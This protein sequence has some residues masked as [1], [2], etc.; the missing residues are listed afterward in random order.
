MLLNYLNKRDCD[1]KHSKNLLDKLLKVVT[2]NLLKKEFFFGRY[3]CYRAGKRKQTIC[4]G[5]PETNLALQESAPDLSKC[6]CNSVFFRE[7]Q[8]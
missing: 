2:D 5:R 7:Q 8:H 6:L 3:F 4:Y 1:K